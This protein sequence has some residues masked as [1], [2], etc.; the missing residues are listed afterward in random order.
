VG[1]TRLPTDAG[2]DTLAD[3]SAPS[4]KATQDVRREFGE[5]PVVV[6]A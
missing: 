3:S 5:E 1:A 4:Y 6:L 2:I